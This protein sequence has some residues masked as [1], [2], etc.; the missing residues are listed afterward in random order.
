MLVRFR[1][2]LL[3][4]TVILKILRRRIRRK[5]IQCKAMTRLTGIIMILTISSMD[6]LRMFLL[7]I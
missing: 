1:I 5:K 6:D 2:Y 7:I 3:K 4:G